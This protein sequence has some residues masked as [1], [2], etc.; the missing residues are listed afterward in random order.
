MK[1]NDIKDV[2]LKLTPQNYENIFDVYTDENGF[3]YY[4]II[5]TINFPTDLSLTTYS[6]YTTVT[7][8]TWPLIA[9]KFYRNVKLWWAICAANQVINPVTP[10]TPGTQLKIINVVILKTLLNNLE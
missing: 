7:N 10:P 1:Q 6:S 9:W 2:S 5:K 8:D 4:N 3:Y